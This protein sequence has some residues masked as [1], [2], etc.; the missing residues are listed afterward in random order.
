M[1]QPFSLN[2]WRDL[3]NIMQGN[4]LVSFILSAKFF[5]IRK[6]LIKTLKYMCRILTILNK[7]LGS[8]I[9]MYDSRIFLEGVFTETAIGCT[10]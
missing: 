2:F 3:W 1:R 10:E 6:V 8:G 9:N 7:V 4:V 5:Y